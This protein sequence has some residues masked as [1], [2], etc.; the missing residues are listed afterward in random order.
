MKRKLLIPMILV[1]L[2][3]GMGVPAAMAAPLQP[4]QGDIIVDEGEVVNNDVVVLDGDLEIRQGAV[5]NGDVVVFNGD[6]EVDGR[7]NGSL[8]LFNGDLEAGAGAAISGDCVLL[9]GEARGDVVPGNCTAIQN[10]NLEWGALAEL[11]PQ[12]FNEPPI[13]AVPAIPDIPAVPPLPTLP[14]MPDMPDMPARV[15]EPEPSG[16]FHGVA[17]IVGVLL[18][19]VLMGFLGLIAAAIAPENLR[20]VV[21]V[22]RNK[23]VTSGAAGALTAVAVPSLIVLLIPL[24]VILT[25]VCIGLLGFPIILLL[26][27]GLVVGGLFGWVAVGTAL[28]NRLF[29]RDGGM[30]LTATAA[31][32]T[33]LLTL[34][35]GMLGLLPFGF[36]AGL[37]VFVFSAIGLGAVALTQFGMKPYPRHSEPTPPPGKNPDKVEEV[38]LTLAPDEIGDIAT[39][40]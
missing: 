15:V 40:R 1:L 34:G 11:A 30:R 25:F 19:A 36:L 7:V 37:M 35:V 38:L 20:Q 10:L 9:N 26:A 31:L 29:N 24:S 8:T 14:P 32:G 12:W 4:G 23:P 17:R 16:F 21:A 27:I 33:G 6:A 2:L 28:G 5:V 18:S 13:P 22:T 39:E 3:M